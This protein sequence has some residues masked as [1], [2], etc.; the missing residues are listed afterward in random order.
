MRETDNRHTNLEAL[1][2]K[3]RIAF[4]MREQGH[5]RSVIAAA[6]DVNPG[7]LS[8]WFSRAKREGYQAVIDGGKRGVSKGDGRSLT[9]DQESRIQQLLCTS[10]PEDQGLADA[11]WTRRAVISLVKRRCHV[12]LPLTTAGLYL[13]RWGFTPQKPAR[14]AYERQPEAVKQWLDEDYPAIMARAQAEGAEIHWGDETGVRN[15]CQHGRSYAPRGQ[16]PVQKLSGSRFSLN[17]ISTVSNQGTVRFMLYEERFTKEVMIRFLERLI[18]GSR[19]KVFLILDNLKVHHANKVKE[20]VAGRPEK[21][22]LFFL[23]AYSPDL[24]PD[25]YLNCDLKAQVH[26]GRATRNKK[27]LKQRVN[28]AMRLLQK[29]PE[30]IK[31]YFEHSSIAY[32]A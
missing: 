31:K 14:Q 4:R 11:L 29:H 6:V 3:R 28:K 12:T 21:I 17:M 5:K 10:M 26:S 15:H 25:E 2:E 30:R 23:P 24:N 1:S 18:K 9:P 22:E 8:D 19:K 32:A 20:W 7:T 16:T 27:Q 13:R